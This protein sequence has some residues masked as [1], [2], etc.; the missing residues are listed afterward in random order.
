M[1][2]IGLLLVLIAAAIIFGAVYDGA[3]PAT[4]EAF[5]FDTDTTVAG[6]FFTGVVTTV[7]FFLG[8]WLLK[9][10][11]SRSRKQRFER[12]QQRARQ[13]ESVKKLEQERNELRAENERLAKQASP[14]AGD[15]TPDAT[16][17]R[18][19]NAPLE[20]NDLTPSGKHADVAAANKE[21]PAPPTSSTTT[22]GT[23]T[24][25]APRR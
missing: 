21:Q 14:P 5:G 19:P 16:Q 3:E 10:A 2:V 13:R 6:V 1:L 8:L 12:K 4:M 15:T 9:S 25:E 24:G 22:D 18:D 17:T 23:R 7:L 11:T 20:T